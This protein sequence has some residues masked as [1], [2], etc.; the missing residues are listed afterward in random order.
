MSHY[1]Q[2]N[3]KQAVRYLEKAIVLDP[4]DCFPWGPMGTAYECLGEHQK[5]SE[6]YKKMIKICL[7]Q[8]KEDPENENLWY[9]MG[10]AYDG[11]KQHQNAIDCY[12]RAVNINPDFEDAWYHIAMSPLEK[13]S[14]DDS[15][16]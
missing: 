5:A 3:Y 13:I 15:S 9:H 7:E 4:Q 11:L 16:Q 8:L 12:K 14:L 2:E 6:C 1:Y 10:R